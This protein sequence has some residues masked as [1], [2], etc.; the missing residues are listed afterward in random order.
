MEKILTETAFETFYK[1]AIKYK[2]EYEET[3]WWM[4]IKKSEAKKN[5]YSARECMVKYG[6]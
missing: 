1:M 5:W 6:R 2:K 4:F 3:P